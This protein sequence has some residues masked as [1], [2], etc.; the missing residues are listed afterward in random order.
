MRAV[1]QLS[2]HPRI[3]QFFDASLTS[4]SAHL[5]L[6]PQCLQEL[7][8]TKPMPHRNSGTEQSSQSSDAV[9][10]TPQPAPSAAVADAAAVSL[11]CQEVL[12]EVTAWQQRMPATALLLHHAMLRRHVL[13]LL[14]LKAMADGGSIHALQRVCAGVVGGVQSNGVTGSDA[15]TYAVQVHQALLHYDLMRRDGYEAVFLTNSAT[16]AGADSS[17][18]EE[19]CQATQGGRKAPGAAAAVGR[20]P[21]GVHNSLAAL[22]VWV[23]R[24]CSTRF[25]LE[26]VVEIAERERQLS[27]QVRVGLSGR[28]VAFVQ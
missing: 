17:A 20:E 21:A 12:L 3:A 19:D 15:R 7:H 27:E 13:M 18:T 16:N 22:L 11:L 4:V 25:L 26:Q 2:L 8:T 14:A 6:L 9:T 28:C 5:V 24:N 1:G 23:S 10:A